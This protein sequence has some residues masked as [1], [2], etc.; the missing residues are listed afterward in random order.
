MVRVAHHLIEMQD[1]FEEIYKILKP[2]GYF[3]LEFANSAHFKSRVRN[4]V[5]FRSVPLGPMQVNVH[6]KE[7]TFV[8]HH[9]TT[10][11]KLLRQEGFVILSELSVSNFRSPILK[12]LFS[13]ETLLLWERMTQKFFVPI[14]FGPSIFILAKR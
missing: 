13:V 2:G 1:S 8:N 14:H 11:K 5:K 6:E 12:R 7:V 10:V 3:I 9:P 4:F